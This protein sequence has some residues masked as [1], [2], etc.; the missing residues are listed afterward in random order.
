M[1][2]NRKTQA[3]L[4][5]YLIVCLQFV[6]ISIAVFFNAH[7]QIWE[8]DQTK[9]SFAIAFLWLMTTILIGMWHRSTDP[10]KIRINSKIG[11]YFAETCL[12]IGMIGT[13]AGFLL[14]LGGA[15][16]NIDVSDTSSLQAALSSMAVGMST[17]LYTTLIG[18]IA[19]IFLKSQLVNLEHY[20]DGLE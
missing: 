2:H 1:K 19:S 16:G 15:F 18:L 7:D 12:A 11:W 5:W 3:S 9:L 14:M 10:Y 6:A 17:A 13:V 8:H 20:A 4:T